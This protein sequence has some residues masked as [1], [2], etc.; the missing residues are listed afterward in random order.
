[1]KQSQRE[2]KRIVV[3]IGSSLFCEGD[4]TAFNA[5]AAEIADLDKNQGKEMVVVSS[6]AIALGMSMLGLKERPKEMYM[7]Q[8]AAAVGQNDVIERYRGIF[9]SKGCH[10]AQILLTRD[11]I[12]RE[13][14][15]NARN[16]I[17]ALLK[18]GVIPVINENDTVSTE[19]IKFGDN[20]LLSALV[21]RL[22]S[23]DLLII[24]S[25]VDGLLDKDKKTIRIVSH[26]TPQIRELACP[27][28]KKACVGG[29]ITKIEAAKI[30]MA[31][32]IPCIIANGRHTNI[33]ASVI[34]EPE[35]HGTMFI[36]KE[37]L[38]E[39][40]HWIAFGTRPKG[41]I[42]VDEGAKRALLNK[43]SLL[44]VGIVACE[45]NFEAGDIVALSDRQ[46]REFARGK[47][48]IGSKE[49]D[50]VKGKRSDKE[51]IH[52]DNIVLLD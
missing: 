39:R 47:V 2:Y 31:S 23:A 29:M 12:K 28:D 22:I 20:D 33:L 21:S 42:I 46:E 38:S 19:E 8:A 13:R 37:R 43:K 3:K 34:S 14:H 1:M 18:H 15:L 5:L 24:L 44:S 52:C 10:V 25:D 11:D 50:K 17:N 45:G 36:P 49:L 26:I 6:G 35:K 51:A 40:E 9:K 16:T 48:R 4:F 27:T 41:R 7:L 32:G 30:T